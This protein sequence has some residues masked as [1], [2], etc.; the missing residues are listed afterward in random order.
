MNIQNSKK[1]LLHRRIYDWVLSWAQTK[2]G[3]LVLIILAVLEPI[4]VP[5]PADV[6][7]I[8]MSLGKP[9]KGIYYG[10]ICAG[11]SVLGGTLAF[12]LGLAVGP[13]RV[14]QFFDTFS[15][16]PLA[17]G[18][19]A[20]KALELYQRY[21]FWAVA[22]SALTPVPYMLFSW[23]GGMAQISIFKFIWVSAIFRT[24]RFGVEGLLFFLFGAKARE[25]IDKHFNTATVIV[26]AGLIIAVWLLRKAGTAFH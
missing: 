23:L 9:R 4:F 22:I 25:W 18:N 11:F 14:V 13:E 16:G 10:L 3:L 19:K 26:M 21:D 5:I 7:V 12:L 15:F 24:M 8:G 17:L 2:Y 6:M 1:F 20:Q